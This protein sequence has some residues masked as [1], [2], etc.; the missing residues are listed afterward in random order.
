MVSNPHPKLQLIWCIFMHN[1]KIF[2]TFTSGQLFINVTI[3]PIFYSVG[4]PKNT[5]QSG[6][7][8]CQISSFTKNMSIIL[9]TC[10][11]IFTSSSFYE[12]CVIFL[13]NCKKEVPI[14]FF[15]R[16][17]PPNDTFCVWTFYILVF[18]VCF[19]LKC[20]KTGVKCWPFKL[21][22]IWSACI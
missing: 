22:K 19:S 6:C 11:H 20:G 17:P 1:Q 7:H 4:I 10:V 9:H 16:E 13:P 18:A 2:Y 21:M 14:H 15:W 8:S 12:F 5:A 3:V